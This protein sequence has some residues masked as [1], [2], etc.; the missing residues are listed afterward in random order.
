MA[1]YNITEKKEKIAAYRNTI[2]AKL[3]DNLRE[4][5]TDILLKQKKYRDSGY[6][7]RQLSEDLKA[8][9]RYISA[10]INVRFG[11]NY[12]TLVNKYRIDEAKHILSNSKHDKLR[13]EQVGQEV[14]FRNRQSFYAA[15]FRFTGIT[16]REYKLRK[17]TEHAA[18]KTQQ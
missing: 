2:S 6:S 13:I 1:K 10:A 8:N 17:R 9:P 3:M 11:M 15:F 4:Q 5:I 14:G 18:F 7:A 16:P 12:S